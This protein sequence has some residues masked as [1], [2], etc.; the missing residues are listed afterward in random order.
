MQLLLGRLVVKLL[1]AFEQIRFVTVGIDKRI[2]VTAEQ[3]FPADG[4]ARLFQRLQLTENGRDQFCD[5]RMNVHGALNHRVWRV[6]V[7]DVEDGMNYLVALDPQERRSKDLF[8]KRSG[9]AS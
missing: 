3:A 9:V 7:H 1:L 8:R 2:R 5:R 4:R 6:G